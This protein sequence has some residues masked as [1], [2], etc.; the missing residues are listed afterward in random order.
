MCTLF[1]AASFPFPSSSTWNRRFSSKMTELGDGLAQAASTLVPTQSERNCTS[2]SKKHGKVRKKKKSNKSKFEE[3]VEQGGN[4]QNDL[5]IAR[6][7]W[8]VE[9]RNGRYS[10]PSNVVGYNIAGFD[11]SRATYCVITVLNFGQS[12]LLR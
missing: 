9:R 8:L 7:N 1:P 2:L 11:Q 5:Y 6:L 12:R 4:V 3:C 10:K